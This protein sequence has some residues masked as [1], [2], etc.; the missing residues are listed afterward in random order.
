MGTYW[1]LARFTALSLGSVGYY[2]KILEMEKLIVLNAVKGGTRIGICN[3]DLFSGSESDKDSGQAALTEEVG[4]KMAAVER[5]IGGR[6][7]QE[8]DRGKERGNV[9]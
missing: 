2:L 8:L 1:E 5:T 6:S 9:G 7:M 3:Y 4:Y